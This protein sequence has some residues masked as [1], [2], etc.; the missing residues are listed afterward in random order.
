MLAGAPM[1]LW[2]VARTLATQAKLG[3]LNASW[4]YLKHTWPA[5]WALESHAQTP[6]SHPTLSRGKG[7]GDYRLRWISTLDFEQS[8]EI[9]PCYPS[10]HINKCFTS[11][12]HVINV[13]S[14]SILL[15]WYSQEIA[16]WSPDSFPCERAGSGHET[17]GSLPCSTSAFDHLQCAVGG[18]QKGEWVKANS[19]FEMKLWSH[20]FLSF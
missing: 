6:P 15:S 10:V 18:M 14:K 1:C 2:V 13:R 19:C 5:P 9:M 16:Q 3:F 17:I 7:S 12:Q 11:F 4:L 20:D 8:N